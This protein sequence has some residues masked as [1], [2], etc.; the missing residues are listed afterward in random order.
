MSIRD[1]SQFFV[2]KHP[3]SV[4]KDLIL[5]QYLTPYLRKVATQ[6]KPILVVDGFAGP[7]EFK[8]GKPGSP[9]IISRIVSKY[10]ANARVPATSLF[11][12]RDPELFAE[13]KTRLANSAHATPV[14]SAFLDVI[15]HIEQCA[16]NGHTVFLYL[17][18][19]AIKGLEWE[20]IAK[21]LHTLKLRT[22]VELLLNFNVTAF[23]RTAYLALKMESP[24]EDADELPDDLS[25]TSESLTR[26]V[27][28]EWWRDA[29][30]RE[31]S[32][33]E[34]LAEATRRMCQRFGEHFNEVLYHEVKEHHDHIPPKYVLVFGS[35]H[36]EALLLMNDAMCKAR[37][38]EAELYKVDG[39][40]F[41]M[42]PEKLVPDQSKLD[43]LLY[44]HCASPIAR[45]ALFQHVARRHFGRFSSSN[46]IQS[47]ERCVEA[48]KLQTSPPGQRLNDNVIL[49]RSRPTVE[50]AGTLWAKS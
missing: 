10:N 48:S 32:Y 41:E 12:E 45:K 9:L 28:G 31:R 7:G 38:S 43:E 21:V 8:D 20:S 42:R 30:N 34:N 15:P 33:S 23:V 37:E 25:G 36:P 16:K 11:I 2:K 13:L 19:F 3:W 22:S 50:G 26:I 35:R 27:G 46:M 29:I 24:P 39:A 14:N 40:F 5:E 4:R 18:P 49:C 1:S 44:E 6:G 47:I 17:D